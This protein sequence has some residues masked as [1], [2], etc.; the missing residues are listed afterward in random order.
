M[1]EM[2][3]LRPS[4]ETEGKMRWSTHVEKDNAPFHLY[5]PKW[6]VPEPWPG[7]IYVA[8]QAFE[9]DPSNV[10]PGPSR[11][12]DL[13]SNIRVLVK[14]VRDH[15]RTRRYAPLG[16]TSEWQIGEPYI[17]YSLIPAD[18]HLLVIEVQWDLRSKGQFLGVPTFRDDR[19]GWGPLS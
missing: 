7:R 1:I 13:E 5:I 3:L 14:P 8:I 15:T 9:G 4:K 11:P 2:V 6:R 16:D 12:T 19:F 18:S 17:P 10:V